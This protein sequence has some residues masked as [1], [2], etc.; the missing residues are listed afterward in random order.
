MGE[1][2][3]YCKACIDIKNAEQILNDWREPVKLTK[4]NIVMPELEMT[5]SINRDALVTY[6]VGQGTGAELMVALRIMS[7]LQE[8]DNSLSPGELSD[9]AR[10]SDDLAEL[11]DVM[12]VRLIDQLFDTVAK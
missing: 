7:R 5:I 6:S 10:L 3:E 9:L 2:S 1:M 4:E 12:S 11:L 8:G